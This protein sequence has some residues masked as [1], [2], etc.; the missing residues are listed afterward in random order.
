[1]NH[2]ARTIVLLSVSTIALCI[3]VMGSGATADTVSWGVHLTPPVAASGTR[4]QFL[5]PAGWEMKIGLHRSLQPAKP[6]TENEYQ[7]ELRYMPAEN[8][9]SVMERY[10][11]SRLPSYEIATGI[12]KRRS[13]GVGIWDFSLMLVKGRVSGWDPGMHE[14]LERM[15]LFK[16][17][18]WIVSRLSPDGRETARIRYTLRWRD[19][20]SASEPTEVFEDAVN[21]GRKFGPV[22]VDASLGLR[23]ARSFRF[24]ASKKPCLKRNHDAQR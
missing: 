10:Q 15:G 4:L 7:F 6:M 24:V 11:L 5:W 3:T 8:R 20:S 21:G 18:D 12:S 13:K 9:K 16:R 17:A 14:S 19:E 2:K 22:P 23:L 1:V